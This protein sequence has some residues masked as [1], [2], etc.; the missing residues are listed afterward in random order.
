MGTIS[1]I[2]EYYHALGKHHSRGISWMK[3]DKVLDIDNGLVR[4]IVAH[5]LDELEKGLMAEYHFEHSLFVEAGLTRVDLV[6]EVRSELH[7]VANLKEGTIILGSLQPDQKI[8]I[9]FLLG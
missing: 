3:N 6:K 7:A 1:N 9:S 5:L 2:S 8:K 4:D